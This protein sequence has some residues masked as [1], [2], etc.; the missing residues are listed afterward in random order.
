MNIKNKKVLIL[1]AGIS[2]CSIAWILKR[3]GADVTLVEKEEECGGIGK[4]YTLDGCKYEFGPHVFHAKKEHTIAFYE[5]YGVRPIEYYAKMSADDTLKNLIDFPYSVDTIFQ[6]PREIGRSVVQELFESEKKDID[7]TS[8]ES[9]L[10]SVVGETLY[11]N[12]NYGY[13]KKFWGK[14]PKDIPANGA[15]TWISLRTDDKRLFLEWQ[16]YPK[17]DYNDFME[18]VKK[19]IPMIQAN[20]NG[21]KTDSNKVLGVESDTGFLT[22]DIYISTIPLKSCFPDMID[23]LEWVGNVL[24]AMKLKN[25]PVLPEGVGGVYFPNKFGFKRMCEYPAMTD[26]EYPNLKNGTLIGFEYNVFPWKKNE[27]TE[28][29]YIDET[30]SACKELCGQEPVATK[31][32]YHKDIYPLRNKEQ[33]S[34]YKQIERRVDN[35]QNFFLNGRFGKF[36]YVNMNDC[37]EM[38]FDLASEITGKDLDQISNEVDL[39]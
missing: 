3:L 15:A 4:T 30:T 2:G 17:G 12:F 32:H 1:G 10:K 19:D 8:L 34:K 31:F 39:F 28:Q 20:I 33:L 18:W 22:S 24:V 5:K 7:Y 38:S 29:E 26:S 25:G 6:L 21:I 13:S 23:D 35:Y 27:I 11:K 16:G 37:I 36:V 14:D 9:Y